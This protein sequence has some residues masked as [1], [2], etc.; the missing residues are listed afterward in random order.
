LNGELI[1]IDITCTSDFKETG[2]TFWKL[3]HFIM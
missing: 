2:Y 1:R 3:V